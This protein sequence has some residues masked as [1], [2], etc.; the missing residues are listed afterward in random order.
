MKKDEPDEFYFLKEKGI[1]HLRAK[2]KSKSKDVVFV[3]A[4]GA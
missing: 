2:V 1:Q 4:R 3:S